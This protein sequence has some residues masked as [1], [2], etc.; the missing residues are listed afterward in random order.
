VAAAALF[1][2]HART[3]LWILLPGVVL[4]LYPTLL[5]RSILLRLQRLFDRTAAAFQSQ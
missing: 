4:H 5:Q 1:S 2:G 3:A